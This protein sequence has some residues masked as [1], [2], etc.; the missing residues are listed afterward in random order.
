MDFSVVWKFRAALLEGTGYTLMLTLVPA[1]IGL[2]IASFI[3]AA[4]LSRWKALRW[5]AVAFSELWRNTPILVQAVWVHF[6]LPMVTGIATSAF[7]SGM[8]TL[9]LNASAY[10][11]EII[12]TGVTSV[13]KGQFEAADALGLSFWP[14]W[15]RVVLPQA[16]P[17]IIPPL[18]GSMISLLKATAA[19]SIL[20]VDDLMK[21]VNRLNSVT[22]RTIELY[23]ASAVIYTL[24]GVALGALAYLVERNFSRQRGF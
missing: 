6:A 23:T 11:G 4:T 2:V 3:C 7:E 15:T 8:I 17:R 14:R 24:L 16:L 1:A 22:F 21:V 10:F 19:L 9:S 12:R 18:T 13:G 20:A 5:P